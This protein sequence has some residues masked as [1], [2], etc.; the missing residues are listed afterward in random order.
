MIGPFR[1][2]LP[3]YTYHRDLPDSIVLRV[4]GRKHG[5]IL[6]SAGLIQLLR[7]IVISVV[8]SSCGQLIRNTI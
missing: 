3:L 6:N 8:T 1:G 2:L 5:G 7:S 4:P